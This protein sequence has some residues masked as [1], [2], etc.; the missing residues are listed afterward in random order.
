MDYWYGVVRNA[1]GVVRF[2]RVDTTACPTQVEFLQLLHY[3]SA[4][5]DVVVELDRGTAM[6]RAEFTAYVHEQYMR[7]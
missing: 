6:S 5:G 1:A 4:A 7:A 3:N 2:L